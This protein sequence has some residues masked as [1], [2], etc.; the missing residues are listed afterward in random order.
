MSRIARIAAV[1][2][3][4]A[5]PIVATAAP[6]TA[7]PELPDCRI[8]MYPTMPPRLYVDCPPL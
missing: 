5:A 2:A 8:G 6:A 1:V 7:G 4:A 3:L